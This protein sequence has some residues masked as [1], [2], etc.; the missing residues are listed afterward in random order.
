M[1]TLATAATPNRHRLAIATR[2]VCLGHSFAPIIATSGESDPATMKVINAIRGVVP[3]HMR[4]IVAYAGLADE[5]SGAGPRPLRAGIRPLRTR[6]DQAIN[7]SL[8]ARVVWMG[9][10]R[11]VVAGFAL[12]LGAAHGCANGDTGTSASGFGPGPWQL[13]GSSGDQPSQTDGDDDTTGP[14]ATSVADSGPQTSG[15]M[16]TTDNGTTGGPGPMGSTDDGPQGGTFGNDDAGMQPDSGW[17][18]HCIPSQIACDPGFACLSTDAMNDG[19][20]TDQCVP[21]GD[22]SS[23]GASPGGT[24]TPVCLSVGGDSVCALGCEN[25]E[26]CPG[27]MVCINES[28]D[29]GPISICI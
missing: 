29:T 13:P 2:T 26:T 7:G 14:G 9:T 11:R 12:A 5:R 1:N 18:A 8:W 25:G 3:S 4:S 21:A 6:T 15:P 19:V 24:S 17:W 22:A 20:C 28:D 10:R 27:G 23:C 16:T